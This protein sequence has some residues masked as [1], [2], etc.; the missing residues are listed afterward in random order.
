MLDKG[1]KQGSGTKLDYQVFHKIALYYTA[2]H[3]TAL[4]CTGLDCTALH[5][6]ALHCHLCLI[7]AGPWGVLTS[8]GSSQDSYSNPGTGRAGHTTTAQHSSSSSLCPCSCSSSWYFTFR[9]LAVVPAPAPAP[10][11]PPPSPAVV[12]L[13]LAGSLS[14][15][16]EPPHVCLL[17]SSDKECGPASLTCHNCPALVSQCVQL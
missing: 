5:C 17:Q 16:W 9:P 12:P 8:W 11:L 1:S 14:L 7:P 13:F 15:P 3:C 6:T 4:D 10:I 2:L